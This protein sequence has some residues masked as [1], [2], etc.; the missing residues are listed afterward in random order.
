MPTRNDLFVDT[1]GWSYY[2]DSRDALYPTFV[3]LVRRAI[4]QKRHLITTNYVITELVALLQSRHLLPRPQIIST[5]N[6]MKADPTVEI[7]HIDAATDDEAWKL[8]EARHDK[9]WS[10]VDASSFVLMWRHGMTEALTTD[11]HFTQAGFTR[12]PGS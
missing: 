10:L 4:R 6:R 5:V 1:S 9:E 3:A 11:Q 2:F 8:L 12:L 7:L